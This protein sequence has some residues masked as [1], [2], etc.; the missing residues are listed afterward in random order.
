MGCVFSV[1]CCVSGRGRGNVNTDKWVFNSRGLYEGLFCPGWTH[2][3]VTHRFVHAHSRLWHKNVAVSHSLCLA[4]KYTDK[5]TSP[6]GIDS[7]WR[8]TVIFRFQTGR[9]EFS[10]TYL[11]RTQAFLYIYVFRTYPKYLSIKT[12]LKCQLN[13]FLKLLY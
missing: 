7:S 9:N 3:L 1:I 10:V 12:F 8:A 11:L 2:I 5:K 13:I 6:E 4:R